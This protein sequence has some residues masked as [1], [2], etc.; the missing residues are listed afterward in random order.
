MAEHSISVQ[1]IPEMLYRS[2]CV[3][4]TTSIMESANEDVAEHPHQQ[5][6]VMVVSP[7]VPLCLFHVEKGNTSLI[8]RGEQTVLPSTVVSKIKSWF[9]LNHDLRHIGDSIL[10]QKIWFDPLRLEIWFDLLFLEIRFGWLTNRGVHRPLQNR[11]IS[12]AASMQ[13]F[14]NLQHQVAHHCLRWSFATARTTCASRNLS[15]ETIQ[16]PS[17]HH[18]WQKVTLSCAV[19]PKNI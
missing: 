15:D 9:D 10:A 12:H 8:C 2:E 17:G 7:N 11:Q 6:V 16:Q 14:L 5:P 1:L 4:G 3:I 13:Y 19:W 18:H